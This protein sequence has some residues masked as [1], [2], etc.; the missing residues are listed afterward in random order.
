MPKPPFFPP[1][2]NF[3]EPGELE[4]LGLVGEVGEAGLSLAICF[5][6]KDG[7]GEAS[8]GGGFGRLTALFKAN[9]EAADMIKLC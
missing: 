2:P 7:L 1:G 3:L 8:S 9:D 6:A 5:K 4:E